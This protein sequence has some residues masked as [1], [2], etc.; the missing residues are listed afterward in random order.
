MHYKNRGQSHSHAGFCNWLPLFIDL[1]EIGVGDH[2]FILYSS[3][4]L[5][6][7]N[8]CWI[9]VWSVCVLGGGGHPQDTGYNYTEN[10][11]SVA[12]LSVSRNFRER[13]TDSYIYTINFAFSLLSTN[14]YQCISLKRGSYA[15]NKESE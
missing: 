13:K 6:Q 15:L 7:I 11:A 8:P 3:A 2:L 9:H 1:Y 5:L 10:S 4:K 12:K 14:F